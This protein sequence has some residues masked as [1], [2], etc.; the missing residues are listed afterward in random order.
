MFYCWIQKKTT[1]NCFKI[2]IKIKEDMSSMKMDM[3]VI[4]GNFSLMKM[5]M[6]EISK[7]V[8]KTEN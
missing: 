2:F 8:K 5:E 7:Y 1:V 6:E 3:K 4:R